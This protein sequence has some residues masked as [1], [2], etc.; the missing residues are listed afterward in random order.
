[1]MHFVLLLSPMLLLYEILTKE[2]RPNESDKSLQK[3]DFCKLCF[4]HL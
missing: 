4:Q 2:N 3:L 1:L